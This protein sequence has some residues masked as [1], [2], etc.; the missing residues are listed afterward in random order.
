MAV[1]GGWTSPSLGSGEGVG[2]LKP[3]T[4]GGFLNKQQE[5][6]GGGISRPKIQKLDFFGPSN[7]EKKK[8]GSCRPCGDYRQQKSADIGGQVPSSQHGQPGSLSGRLQGFQ[9]MRP[10]KRLPSGQSRCR[11]CR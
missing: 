10:Q 5:V 4:P 9:Q 2:L 8:D 3:F 7:G 6:I 11:C 1:G